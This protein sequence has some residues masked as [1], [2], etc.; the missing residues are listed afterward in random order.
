MHETYLDL[1]L[2]LI[3][4]FGQEDEDISRQKTYML[5]QAL[6]SSGVDKEMYRELSLSLAII[7]NRFS[8]DDE[9]VELVDIIN[10]RGIASSANWEHAKKYFGSNRYVAT[11]DGRELDF[12]ELS[13]AGI[14]YLT[15]SVLEPARD[16]TSKVSNIVFYDDGTTDWETVYQV[17]PNTIIGDKTPWYT[18]WAQRFLND[19]DEGRT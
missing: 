3:S 17:Q 19:I 8:V 9:I 13:D 5:L 10:S 15:S 2:E 6:C 14:R 12:D 11:N 18:V 1:V 4:C 16:M 7:K